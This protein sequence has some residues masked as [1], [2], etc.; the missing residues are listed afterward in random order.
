MYDDPPL[1][2]RHCGDKLPWQMDSISWE[3][4]GNECDFCRKEKSNESNDEEGK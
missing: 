4:N 1:R 3:Y 2:C